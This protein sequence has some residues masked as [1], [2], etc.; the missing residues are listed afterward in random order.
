MFKMF[1]RHSMI[2]M[3]PSPQ[4]ELFLYPHYF[5]DIVLV[6][7]A[8]KKGK[9]NISNII[10][11]SPLVNVWAK[12]ILIVSCARIFL[13]LLANANE[14]QNEL[15]YIIFNTFGISFGTTDMTGAKSRPEILLVFFLNLF[16]ILAG[17]LCSGML[18]EQFTFE[19][20]TPLINS[21]D[22]IAN[23]TEFKMTVYMP[24]EYHNTK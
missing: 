9:T 7:P 12:V 16:A 15:A 2:V 24:F 22:D 11:E 23:H 19:S 13:R 10:L 8:I 4:E 18:F 21:L 5:A 3:I 14:T 17:C 6:V 1:S 20:D